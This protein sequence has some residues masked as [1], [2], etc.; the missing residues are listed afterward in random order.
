MCAVSD[1]T[2]CSAGRSCRADMDVPGPKVPLARGPVVGGRTPEQREWRMSHHPHPRPRG[3]ERGGTVSS[4]WGIPLGPRL[5]SMPG[6]MLPARIARGATPAQLT[7]P[8][9]M[10]LRRH[11]AVGRGTPVARG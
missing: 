5:L 7:R 6:K 9:R 3:R 8:D 4:A 2:A 11:G 10:A 1:G